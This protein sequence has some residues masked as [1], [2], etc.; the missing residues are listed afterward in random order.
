MSNIKYTECDLKKEIH[1]FIKENYK[2]PTRDDMRINNGYISS[3][4]YE[5]F[6]NTRK[7]NKILEYLGITDLNNKIWNQD[8]ILFLRNNWENFSDETIA[9]KLNRTVNSI[10][11]KRNELELYRQNQKQEWQDWEI[12]YLI[13]NFYNASQEEI[14]NTL[15]HRKWETIRAYATKIL[16]LKRKNH[17]YKYKLNNGMRICKKCNNILKENNDNFYTDRNRTYRSYCKKCWSEIYYEKTY[18]ENYKQ[19]YYELYKNLYDLN[20]EKCDS[21]P[22]KIITNWFI[23][24]NIKY[25]KQPYYKDYVEDKTNRRFDWIVIKNNSKYYIEYFGLWDISSKNQYLKTYTYKAKKKIKL[26]YKY[27]SLN[28]CICIFPY[29]L[30]NKSLNEIFADISN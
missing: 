14:E 29:D 11:Y 20:N 1:R 16:K 22:E 15:N 8:E 23:K 3:Y 10:S 26:L 27:N 21:V 6:Y 19:T 12:Q 25:I 13:Y 24:N 17:L 2:I 5:K 28:N 9:K 18:G 4:Q 30:K 7:W